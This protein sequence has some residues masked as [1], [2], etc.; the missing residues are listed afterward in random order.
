MTNQSYLQ[1]EQLNGYYNLNYI[2]LNPN[3]S[4][5]ISKTTLWSLSISLFKQ[6]YKSFSNTFLYVTISVELK[7]VNTN[8]VCIL[9][10]I[11]NLGK[12]VSMTII[13]PDK[14][15]K[16]DSSNEYYLDISR[17]DDMAGPNDTIATGYYVV[18][19]KEVQYFINGI[20]AFTQKTDLNAFIKPV[21]ENGNRTGHERLC[22][23]RRWQPYR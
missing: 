8:M 11:D 7:V 21:L 1:L 3:S 4:D 10:Y 16:Y 13:L 14:A 6:E 19:Q 20:Y 12:D 2:V 17:I 15:H 23:R 22:C 18:R 9:S 5:V